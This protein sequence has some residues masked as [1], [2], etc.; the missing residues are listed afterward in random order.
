MQNNLDQ[1]VKS[2]QIKNNKRSA[3]RAIQ[4]KKSFNAVVEERPRRVTTQVN[5][6]LSSVNGLGGWRL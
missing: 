2:Q 4:N 5:D 3:Q 1:E 6:A